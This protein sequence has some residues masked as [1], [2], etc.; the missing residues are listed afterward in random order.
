MTP[1]SYSAFQAELVRELQRKN[2]DLL[3]SNRELQ[4]RLQQVSLLPHPP[5]SAKGT[6]S[7]RWWRVPL[8]QVSSGDE[9]EVFGDQL[10]ESSA[11]ILAL[12]EEK[13]RLTSIVD[14][15]REAVGMPEDTET[16]VE[17]EE[18]AAA[19]SVKLEQESS[20]LHTAKEE[21]K[22]W[23]ATMQSIASILG[24][25]AAADGGNLE[26]L[27]RDAVAKA[28][29]FTIV[30]KETVSSLNMRGASAQPSG[31]VSAAIQAEIQ[32]LHA[33]L[34][35]S[36]EQLN[37]QGQD[38][39]SQLSALELALAQKGA[40][41]DAA[42][43]EAS[44]L[45]G[46]LIDLE[47]RLLLAEDQLSQ[48]ESHVATLR[49]QLEASASD[50][51]DLRVKLSSAL[52]Q[53]IADEGEDNA[54]T[55]AHQEELE[56]LRSEMAAVVQQAQEHH[57]QW[58]LAYE[59]TVRD[60]T[61]AERDAANL[62]VRLGQVMAQSIEDQTGLNE[63]LMLAEAARLRLD[64]EAAALRVRLSEVLAASIEERDAAAEAQA[65]PEELQAA[66][67]EIAELEMQVS[68]HH[69]DW[70]AAYEDMQADLNQ[71]L[72]EMRET[73]SCSMER[74]EAL[75]SELES[76]L[77]SVKVMQATLDGYAAEVDSLRDAN[78]ELSQAVE[79]QRASYQ[80]AEV[81]AE[82]LRDAAAAEA[83][84]CAALRREVE[85]LKE[86]CRREQSLQGELDN[87][88]QSM[89]VMQGTLDELTEEA[90]S[91][92][93]EKE[94][95]AQTVETQR[96]RCQAADELVE[97][98]R[99]AVVAE[100]ATS[101]A[102][103]K[104]IMELSERATSQEVNAAPSA[105]QQELEDL[106]GKV[107][108]L[109]L[110]AAEHHSEWTAAY[111]DM[112][113]DLMQQLDQLKDEVVRAE[114]V[115]QALRKDLGDLNQRLQD[116]TARGKAAESGNEHEQEY[117]ALA[118]LNA[119]LVDLQA[120]LEQ[121]HASALENHTQWEE[122]Y[123]GLQDD[124]HAAE[125]SAKEAEARVAA[126]SSEQGS[127]QQQISGSLAQVESLQRELGE[128]RSWAATVSADTETE[129][130]ALREALLA[131]QAKDWEGK[132][133]RLR[134]LESEVDSLRRRL[135]DVQCERDG[136]A[137]SVESLRASLAAEQSKSLEISSL[138]E[139]AKAEAS[140]MHEEVVR[141]HAAE[142]QLSSP[143][144]SDIRV[145]E[146]TR[147][148]D[149]LLLQVGCAP[150]ANPPM[151]LLNPVRSPRPCQVEHLAAECARLEEE[152]SN[153]K[154]EQSVRALQ[155]TE[156]LQARI[157]E[158]E[159]SCGGGGVAIRRIASLSEM[160]HSVLQTDELERLR[161]EYA[162]LREADG[163]VR[164]LSI[165]VDADIDAL[166]SFHEVRNSI[167]LS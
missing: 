154:V 89:N 34:A 67:D 125:A 115:E 107:A 16:S 68:T 69:A 80:S 156:Q 164:P 94:G 15:V 31:D 50:S 116:E 60:K 113:A 10:R 43:K 138:L 100:S 39:V 135:V 40:E 144:G 160:A 163:E 3:W 48:S 120:E 42:S 159:E 108:D 111:E 41:V 97:Q 167:C 18:L 14:A 24:T 51:R 92:R 110:Q 30:V 161:E 123:Q 11:L 83:E 117:T 118:D 87:A 134:Q 103:R 35:S 70:T 4:D 52:A 45:R 2:N 6:H 73:Q 141:S 85:E 71:Q 55:A 5:H 147:E 49:L 38:L 28:Q 21:I 166:R 59:E 126:L 132:E 74:E 128:V 54:E 84:T 32:R 143:P 25:S 91:L 129:V 33:E 57:S 149:G 44:S 81:L 58:V 165:P 136:A 121:A 152:F 130:T 37:V 122:A 47:H 36:K 162:A 61:E 102:L 104:D 65:S 139:M 88:L 82:Q 9:Y 1:T 150:T 53:S 158:L 157:K 64:E 23:T 119:Q 19:I 133:E 98:L 96:A 112:Q 101:E 20:A 75:R 109:E 8:S 146:L 151:A 66:R 79:A 142:P 22:G 72:D 26:E 155:G 127:M 153:R 105:E 95:L 106:R 62:R 148:R 90:D 63:N 93:D 13:E 99:A 145:Q 140:H 56:A 7:S 17:D 78:V 77:R 27:V 114:G 29:E 46:Q 86:V 12:R 76:A 137:Q 131:E 124:L